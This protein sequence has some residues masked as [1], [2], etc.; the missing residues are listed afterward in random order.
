MDSHTHYPPAGV[1]RRIAAMFYDS[2]LLFA[3][4]FIATALAGVVVNQG[5]SL[6]AVAEGETVNDIPQ[7][8]S[9]WAFQLYLFV[10]TALFYSIFWR[11]NGQTLGMQAWRI[12]LQQTDGNIPSWGHCLKRVLAAPLALLPAGLGLWWIWID[13]EK[14]SWHD[15]LSGTQVVILPKQSR[16]R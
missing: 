3:V 15:R 12:Q 14:R 5:A 7:Q 13:A 6:P 1:W 10:I 9:G 16:S 11:K 2:F 8:V 4:L